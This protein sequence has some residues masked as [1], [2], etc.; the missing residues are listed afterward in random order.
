MEVEY[1]F[2]SF[3]IPCVDNFTIANSN[4]PAFVRGGGGGGGGGGAFKPM[5]D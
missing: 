3:C 2:S 4:V 1:P 5:K